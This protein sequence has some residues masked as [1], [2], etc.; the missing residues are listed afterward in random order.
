MEKNNSFSLALLLYAALALLLSTIV[1]CYNYA[2]S[3]FVM[4]MP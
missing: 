3:L 1:V 4:F 2:I